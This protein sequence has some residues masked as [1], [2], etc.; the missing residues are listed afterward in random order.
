MLSLIEFDWFQ[1]INIYKCNSQ[2][3]HLV[4]EE[5]EEVV[6]GVEVIK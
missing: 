5:E 6:V 2:P 4:V 3:V 1:I